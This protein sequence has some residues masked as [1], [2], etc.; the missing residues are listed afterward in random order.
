MTL[1]PLS[2][3]AVQF[4]ERISNI[5]HRAPGL[6]KLNGPS[7]ATTRRLV[8]NISVVITASRKS[9]SSLLLGQ[10]FDVNILRCAATSSNESL[11][12]ARCSE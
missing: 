4:Y 8:T 1:A 6:P 11:A 10:R 9:C 7:F 12:E 3:H 2:E 5:L